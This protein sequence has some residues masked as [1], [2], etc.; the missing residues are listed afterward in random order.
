MITQDATPNVTVV[1]V[2]YNAG[3]FLVNCVSKAIIQSSRIIVVDNASTDDSLLLCQRLFPDTQKLQVIKNSSNLGFATACNIGFRHVSTDYVLFLNPDCELDTNAVKLMHAVLE[4]D[5]KAGMAGG[6]LLNQDGSEQEGGRR[7]I[8]TPMRAMIRAFG[9]HRLSDKWPALFPDFHLHRQPIP[10]EPIEVD[11]ISGACMLVK[12]SAMIEVGLWD[13]KYF[14]HCEDL[15]LCMRFKQCARKIIFVPAAHV[16]HVKGASS[17]KIPV[18]VEWHKHKGMIRF[19][20]KYFLQTYP[21][22]L[23]YLVIIA[24][25][26]RFGLKLAYYSARRVIQSFTPS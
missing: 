25:W 24:V 20:N 13:E 7:T 18:F 21:L 4:H 1:I 19:Y 9:L 11:A 10:L 26:L 3:K 6:L 12:C 23:K 15:D 5:S 17:Q 8:P 2:N 16:V 22:P 14:L